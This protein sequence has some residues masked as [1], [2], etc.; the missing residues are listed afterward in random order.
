M[1]WLSSKE[2]MRKLNISSCKLM[3]RREHGALEYKKVGNSYFYKIP[4]V[5]REKK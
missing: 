3:H 1:N 5:E 4:T 2:T